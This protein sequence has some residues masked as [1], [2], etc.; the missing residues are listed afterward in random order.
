MVHITKP[1]DTMVFFS[2]M[3]I[4]SSR[5]I[6]NVHIANAFTSSKEHKAQHRRYYTRNFIRATR[7]SILQS[8]TNADDND[9]LSLPNVLCVGETLWDSLPSGIYLGG[10]PSN[11]AVHLAYLFNSPS[12]SS[13]PNDDDNSSSRATGQP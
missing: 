11:V 13:T 9:D 12:S 6:S 2:M 4:L 3:F 8:S 1:V 5:I 10:A 7:E